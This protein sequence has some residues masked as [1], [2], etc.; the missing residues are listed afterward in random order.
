M[1]FPR[2][3]DPAV[4]VAVAPTPTVL[5]SFDVATTATLTVQ[6]ENTDASQTLSCDIQRRAITSAPFVSTGS[7]LLQDIQPLASACVD[8][9]VAGASDVRI[10]GTASGAGLTANICGRDKPRGNR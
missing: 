6:V 5:A 10:V 2:A 3:I 9:D 4:S 1:A 8:V 7:F